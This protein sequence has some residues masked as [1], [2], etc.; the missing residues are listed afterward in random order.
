MNPR[1]LTAW[2][3][4]VLLL[5]LGSENPVLRALVLA[6]ALIWLWRH[7]RP[8][9]RL[10]PVLIAVLVASLVT[11]LL[12]FTLGHTGQ[13]VL[14]D[15][16]G[17]L[18]ALG[19]PMT[20]EGLVYGADL[21]LGLAACLLAGV[22]LSLAA[23]PWGLVEALP[24]QLARTAAALGSAM[25]LVPRLGRSFQA[26]REAQQL[27][28][29]RGRGP[30]SWSAVAVPA[31]LTAIE[32]SVLLAEAM[33]ARAYGSG[34]RTRLRRRRLSVGERCLVASCLLAAGGFLLALG[35]GQLPAWQPYPSPSWPALEWLP[36][37]S[38][39]LLLGASSVL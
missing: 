7:R 31:V 17:W 13:D 6:A 32:G 9:A 20:L 33:E 14:L 38:C 16:P 2:V 18:P 27:R 26:V 23:D 21:A 25:T 35:L 11:V 8:E 36:L 24:A 34:P 5:S 12:S 39:L 4:A 19:G 1:A 10:R 28:G 15:L 29:W 37:A 30:R 3:G 22:S